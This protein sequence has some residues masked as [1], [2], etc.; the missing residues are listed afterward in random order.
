MSS[1]PLDGLALAGLLGGIGHKASNGATARAPA[2][3]LAPF[4]FTGWIWTLDFDLTLFSVVAGIAGLIGVCAI[5]AA[6]LS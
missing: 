6:A 2:I 1:A 5:T 3:T 4:D